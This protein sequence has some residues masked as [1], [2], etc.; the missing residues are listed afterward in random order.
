V[1]HQQAV[2]TL[3][4]KRGKGRKMFKVC[5]FRPGPAWRF[6]GTGQPLAQDP[7]KIFFSTGTG[8]NPCTPHNLLKHQDGF[9]LNYCDRR[10][11]V[12]VMTLPFAPPASRT[13]K[14][15]DLVKLPIG[16]SKR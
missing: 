16:V 12:I 6:S 9:T 1:K 14:L 5:R 10:L 11:M 8:C 2:C 3:L 15:S 4:A 7:G 13:S